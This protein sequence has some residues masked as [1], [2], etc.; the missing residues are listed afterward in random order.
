[1]AH[2]AQ[3]PAKDSEP[4]PSSDRLSIFED[5]LDKLDKSGKD[6]PESGGDQD[7]D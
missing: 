2:S 7:E 6:K 5:F 4:A 1:V 3:A